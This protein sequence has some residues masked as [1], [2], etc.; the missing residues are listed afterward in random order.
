M[1]NSSIIQSQVRTEQVITY[2]WVIL[3]LLTL[4]QLFMSLGAYSWGPLAPFLIESFQFSRAQLGTF[5]SALYLFAALTAIPSGLLVDRFGARLILI[6]SLPLMGIPFA[7]IALSGNYLTIL[8]LSALSGLSYGVINQISTK[9]I[10]LW[11]TPQSRGTAMGIKQTGVALA[12]ALGAV[13]IPIVGIAWGWRATVAII[14][15]LMIFLGAVI[16]FL[17]RDSPPRD[18]S[19]RDDPDT[20]GSV[21]LSNFKDVLLHPELR[22]IM[23][24]IPLLTLAQAGFSTFFILFLQE[25][26]SFSRITAGSYLT[27]AMI[28]GACG[29][30]FWGF[31][32]DRLFRGKRYGPVCILTTVGFATILSLSLLSSETPGWVLVVLT[33]I[34]GL[35]LLG[36]NALLMIAAAEV[37][38]TR[39]AASIMGILVT[40]AWIGMVLGP[41]MFGVFVDAFGY[42]WAWRMVS[43]CVAINAVGFYWLNKSMK[44]R[45][46][47]ME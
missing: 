32:S 38:G 20:S 35:T 16:L 26:H 14:G 15:L 22:V 40:I 36:W 4:S 17:Y 1:P 46:P 5:S 3:S 10:M 9:G 31:V 41:A 37:A 6:V 47:K 8:I 29:R 21:P 33:L 2:K 44:T 25:T 43:F 30:I 45:I 18:N 7:A 23:G 27:M 34:I 28:A 24:L 39:M 12:A 19:N 11:F 42:P 13:L